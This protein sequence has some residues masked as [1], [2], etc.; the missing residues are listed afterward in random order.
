MMR[1]I[2]FLLTVVMCQTCFGQKDSIRQK[3]MQIDKFV[4][5]L[6]ENN[7]QAIYDMTYHTPGGFLS[8]TSNRTQ[9]VKEASELIGKYG[10]P[11]QK[12]WLYTYDVHNSFERFSIEIPLLTH[13]D[14]TSKFRMNYAALYIAFPPE[15]ISSHIFEFKIKKTYDLKDALQ[16]PG[17]A[18]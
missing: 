9:I 6:K 7:Q 11:P 12:K 13:L 16:A 15:E 4:R 2:Y 5:Y 10:L 8:S 17:P 18:R 1:L 3:Q 14:S